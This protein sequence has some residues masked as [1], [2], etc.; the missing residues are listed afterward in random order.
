MEP[1]GARP[2][3]AEA[4]ADGRTPDES[5][6]PAN[7]G[8]LSQVDLELKRVDWSKCQWRIA[9]R[10]VPAI[11]LLLLVGVMYNQPAAG[12]LAAGAAL[13]VGFSGMR[14]LSHSRLQAMLATTLV[15]AVSTLA[16]C[17]IG[18]FQPA[19]LPATFLFGFASGLLAVVDEDAG[20]ITMQGAIAYLIASAFPSALGD[21]LLRAAFIAL[22]G[23][24]QAFCIL[25]IWR[26]EGIGRFGP[27]TEP[28]NSPGGTGSRFLELWSHIIHPAAE[29]TMAYSTLAFRFAVRVG[30]TL[31][32]AVE[33]DRLLQLK[34][35]YWLPMTTLVV[36][37]P[38]FTHTYT[39]GVQRTAGTLVGVIAASAI[40]HFL[41]P[42]NYTLIA[43][44]TVL[45][46]CTFAFQKANPVIFS[47]ALT[48][49]AV[50]MIAVTGL[51]EAG[52]MWHRF[53]NTALGCALALVSYSI[54]LYFL[55]RMLH[56]PLVPI[57]LR[58]ALK[59]Q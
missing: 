18:E 21:A 14:Q 31:A 3:P 34:N 4:G 10:R 54:G 36:L 6:E 1:T 20:W 24:A 57:A 16:G 46:F 56:G 32:L 49:F 39:N 30:L 19:L 43:L 27:E 48:S 13:S 23:I 40:A 28:A 33:L 55:R 38:D 52:V 58:T 35:G 51:P 53:L 26:C 8:P 15:M 7:A 17:L 11:T 45:T 12:V 29:S 50:F 25:L 37:K 9:L 22:G 42:E 47:A 59:T 44:V 2:V 41:R 5:K